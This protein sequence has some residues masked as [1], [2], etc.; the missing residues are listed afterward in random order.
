M[1]NILVTGSTGSLGRAV[2]TALKAKGYGIRAAARAPG[3]LPPGGGVEPVLFAYED[4]ATHAA[5]LQGV[6]GVFLMAPPLDPEAPAKLK[7]VIDLAKSRGVRHIVLTS[8]MGVDAVEQAP[9][10]I[11]ERQLMASGVPYT[12]L[13]PNFFMENFSTGFLAPMLKQ[14]GIFLAA[15]DGKTSFISVVDI[16]EAASVVFQKGLVSKEYNLT[17]PEALDH[18]QVA[19]TISE[20]SGKTV[21]YQAIPEDAMLSGLRG[22]GMPEG[23]VQYVRVLYSAVRAGYTA[24][25]TNDIEALTGRKP[26]SFDAFA[27]QSAAVWA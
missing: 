8:A 4:Q 2:V 26:M 13:R 11:V 3:K 16:A 1:K 18:A 27:R 20:V 19:A 25:V 15:A 21:T 7:P 23:S 9:L 22:T 10:R 5:A 12:I 14:R 17:G 6:E 24:A